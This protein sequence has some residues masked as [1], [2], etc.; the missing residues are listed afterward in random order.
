MT[1]PY[2]LVEVRGVEPRSEVMTI[3]LSPYSVHLVEFR[4]KLDG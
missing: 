2:K 1:I 4:S 3:R